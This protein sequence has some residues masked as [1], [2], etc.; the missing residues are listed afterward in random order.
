MKH[1]IT[2]LRHTESCHYWPRSYGF[3]LL[4]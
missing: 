2:D 4:M 3:R 1:F